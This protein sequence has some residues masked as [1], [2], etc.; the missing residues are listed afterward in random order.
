V[1]SERV[2]RINI[3]STMQI[4]AEAKKMK[5][6]G[7][8]VIDLSVGESDFPTPDDI[9]TAAKRAIDNDLTTYTLN[10]GTLETS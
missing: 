4:A 5:S 8:D 1:I 10:A 6:E 3:S 9:K 7:I 2:K